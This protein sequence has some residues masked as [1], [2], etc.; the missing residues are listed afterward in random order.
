MNSEAENRPSDDDLTEREIA[1]LKDLEHETSADF[2]HRVRNKIERRRAASHFALFSWHLPRLILVEIAGL[3][4]HLFTA[5]PGK[6][7]PHP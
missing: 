7:D 3:F 1:G 2:V 4:R 6:K 5:I